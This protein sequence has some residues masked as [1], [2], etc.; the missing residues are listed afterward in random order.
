MSNETDILDWP[1]AAYGDII[2]GDDTTSED[3]V[4]H[5]RNPDVARRLA[6]C[7]NACRGIPTDEIERG[8][9]HIFAGATSS[10]W[11]KKDDNA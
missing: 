1:L 9:I 7:W 6:A 4:G 2:R 3:Q 11:D 5:G 10:L 8:T